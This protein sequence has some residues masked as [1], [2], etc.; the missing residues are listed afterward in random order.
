MAATVVGALWFPL[1]SFTKTT[2]APVPEQTATL[3]LMVAHCGCRGNANLLW[4]FVTRDDDYALSDYVKLDAW[5][6]PDLA[7]VRVTYD[8][9]Q[10]TE[11]DIKMAIVEPYLEME[12]QYLRNSPFEIQGFNPMSAYL[13]G[14]ASE[15]P[16][17]EIEF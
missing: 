11:D 9:A 7:R 16:V 13:P 8:P 5:P 1:P 17:P 2:E 3:E 4:Y 6:S 15:M 10:T 12:D 14:S